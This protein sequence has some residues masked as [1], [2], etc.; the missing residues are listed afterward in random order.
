MPE[1]DMQRHGFGHPEHE[2]VAGLEPDQTVA[3]TSRPFPRYR[4]DPAAD[5]ALWACV[6]LCC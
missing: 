1:P 6:S 5:A 3:A 2:L 4:L